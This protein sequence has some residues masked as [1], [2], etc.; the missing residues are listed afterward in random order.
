M[1]LNKMKTSG[2]KTYAENN[3]DDGNVEHNS[4]EVWEDA[5]VLEGGRPEN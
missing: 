3:D 2:K 1:K 4:H 5:N